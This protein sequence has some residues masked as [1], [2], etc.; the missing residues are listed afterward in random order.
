MDIKL[1][2]EYGHTEGFLHFAIPKW[3]SLGLIIVIFVV[4]FWYARRHPAEPTPER[5][6]V[7]LLTEE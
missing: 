3:L 6:A 7:D 5:D 2:V 4:S 1:L